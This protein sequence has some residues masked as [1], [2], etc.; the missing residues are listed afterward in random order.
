MNSSKAGSISELEI[1]RSNGTIEHCG[2]YHNIIGNLVEGNTVRSRTNPWPNVAF[3]TYSNNGQYSGYGSTALSGTFTLS[4]NTI[5]RVTGTEDFRDNVKHSIGNLY[6]FPS[7]FKGYKLAGNTSLSTI[8][9]S[10]SGSEPESTVT[11]H[12]SNIIGYGLFPTYDDVY[13]Q[14]AYNPFILATTP[15]SYIPLSSS[16]TCFKRVS[17]LFAP[18]LINYDVYRINYWFWS[19]EG[20][21]TQE[22]AN[23]AAG[24]YIDITPPISLSAGDALVVRNFDYSLTYNID[25]PK[26]FTV[27]PIAGITGSGRLQRTIPHILDE[28]ASGITNIS[29]IYLLT[30]S[31]KIDFLSAMPSS[32]YVK[33]NSSI[34][35][36]YTITTTTNNKVATFV[37]NVTS[38]LSGNGTFVSDG[39]TPIQQ[40]IYGEIVSTNFNIYGIIEYD[41]P[42]IPVVG[43]RRLAMTSKLLMSVET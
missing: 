14:L 24:G 12:S 19:I 18:T 9:I 2:L 17:A 40:I 33:L 8:Q 10:L 38:T 16:G 1:I 4:G 13:I 25:A 23:T 39:I 31:N 35:K 28:Y 37:N 15:V 6:E 32:K 26:Y 36:Q 3:C 29:T 42:F 21:P 30:S 34:I 11:H 7:G 20:N 43:T 41:T 5:T 22:N 27:S